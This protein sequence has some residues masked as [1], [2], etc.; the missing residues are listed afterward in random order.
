MSTAADE[1][2]GCCT[3]LSCETRLRLEGSVRADNA[4]WRAPAFSAYAY[5]RDELARLRSSPEA[6][7][8]TA[9]G[10]ERALDEALMAMTPPRRRPEQAPGPLRP[11]PL[12]SLKRFYSGSEIEQAWRAI[13]RAQAAL[14]LLYTPQE[15]VPQAEHVEAVVAELPEQKSLLKSVTNLISSLTSQVFQPPGPS[16]TAHGAASAPAPGV[17][18]GVAGGPGAAP[19]SG[20]APAPAPAPGVVPGVAGGPGAAPVSGVA[21]APAVVP[22]AAPHATTQA[23]GPPGMML[24]GIYERATDVSDNLQAEARS[25]RNALMTASVA[26]FIVLVV[27]GVAHLIE[28]EA[29]RLCVSGGSR[30]ACPLGGAPHPFDVFVVELAGILGGLLSIVI[31]LVTGERIKTPYRVFNQQLILKTLA[32]AA[33]AVGGILLIAGSVIDTIKLEST[34]SILGYAVLFG[35]AQQIVTGGIDRRADSLAKETPTAKSV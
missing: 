13:H 34:A 3:A 4:G 16:G 15:L 18:P 2:Q 21:P 24:R 19:V 22:G 26:I 20:V 27:A 31:P 28:P 9:S 30:T 32:G 1:E 11:R 6:K 7:R 23:G 29:L 33:T 35:F 8:S 5:L 10:A 12:A 17:A 25:L 14:Y